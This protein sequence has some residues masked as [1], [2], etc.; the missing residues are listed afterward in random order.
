MPP[1]PLTPGPSREPA[2]S[3]LAHAEPAPAPTIPAKCRLEADHPKS[4]KK[5]K[6]AVKSQELI[7]DSDVD[8]EPLSTAATRPPKPRPTKQQLAKGKAKK[9]VPGLAAGE[10]EAGPSNDKGKGKEVD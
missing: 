5:P 10:G 9:A 7:K 3:D 4:S 8:E 6:K 1:A 2:N